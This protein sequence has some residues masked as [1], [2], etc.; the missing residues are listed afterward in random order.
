MTVLL[1]GPT[2]QVGLEI[3]NRAA[4]AGIAV[5][6]LDRGSVDLTRPADVERAI[7][8]VAPQVVVNAAAYTEVDKAEGDAEAAFAVNRDAPAA[9]ARACAAAGIP[10]VHISTDYVFDGSK[11]GAY[12]ESDPVAPL[13]VYGTSKEAGE[14]AVR[15][16]LDAHVILRT[17]WVFSAHRK[18]FVKTMLRLG[19]EREE[20]GIVDDQRGGPTAARDIADAVLAIV[21]RIAA[22]EGHWGTFHFAGQPSVTWREFAEAIFER[23]EPFLGRRPRIKP[24]T[25]ADYPLPARRPANSCLD[26]RRI[27][28]EWGVA[29]PDWRPALDVV[30]AELAQ[31]GR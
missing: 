2:G 31:G 21:A 11:A 30:L 15:A 24:I 28:A 14:A 12:V 20:L 9:M 17:A 25:T 13:G 6:A 8:E 10:L 27:T 4:A 23:A 7:A 16:A 5:V 22:G 1:F 29:Q 18:N 3:Q 19:A 26:C